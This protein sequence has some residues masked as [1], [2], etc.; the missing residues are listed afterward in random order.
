MHTLRYGFLA[1]TNVGFV[2]TGYAP[3]SIFFP[4][5]TSVDAGKTFL[6]STNNVIDGSGNTRNAF[7]PATD[8][9]TYF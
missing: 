2:V 8:Q 4:V 3:I 1:D 6:K 9:L 7:A 5:Y